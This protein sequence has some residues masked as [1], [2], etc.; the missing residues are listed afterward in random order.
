MSI[1]RIRVFL[2][3]DEAL[4]VGQCGCR[5]SRQQSLHEHPRHIGL[6]V[7]LHHVLHLALANLLAVVVHQPHLGA[8]SHIVFYGEETPVLGHIVAEDSQTRTVVH[9]GHAA[10]ALVVVHRRRATRSGL[11][12]G[13]LRTAEGAGVAGE[14][15]EAV[16]LHERLLCHALRSGQVWLLED[17]H[18]VLLRVDILA[19][20]VE[21]FVVVVA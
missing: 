14:A 10:Y 17:A 2:F 21:V 11:A 4:D 13:A 19:R 1:Q 18:G 7:F 3:G 12:D 8:I 5:F 20:D 6:V 16:E 9:A 15:V